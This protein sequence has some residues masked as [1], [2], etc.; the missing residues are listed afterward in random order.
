MALC[1]LALLVLGVIMVSSAGMTL[2]Q[3]QAVT[4]TSIVTSKTAM[5]MGL[6]M[7]AML[8]TALL[9]IRRL[10]PVSMR[11]DGVSDDAPAVQVADAG[12]DRRPGALSRWING[13]LRLWPL[14]LGTLGLLAVVASAYVPGIAS[15]R[16]GAH[17]WINLRL[18][19]FDSVQPSEFAKWGMVVLI[20]WFGARYARRMGSFWYGLLPGLV[21]AG[22]VSAL[23]VM[24]DLGTGALIGVSAAVMLLAAGCRWWQFALLAPIPVVGA[25]AAIIQ[26]PYRVDR[27]KAFMDP[28][29]DP[30]GIG[31]H[32]IQSMA[33]VAN[34][35]GVGRGLGNG[36]QKF[37]YL[38]EDTTDFLFAIVCEELGIAGAALVLALYVGLVWAIWVI[39]RRER[40]AVLKLIALGVMTTIGLQAVINLAV[41]TGLGPT[42]GIALPLMS[43]G[44]TGWVLIGAAL[45]LVIA[46]D[47]SQARTGGVGAARSTGGPRSAAGPI[48]DADETDAG[49]QPVVEDPV[50]DDSAVTERKTRRRKVEAAPA[51]MV[52]T[53]DN[54]AD[55]Q[56]APAP[57]PGSAL[58]A[59]P[60]RKRARDSA[61]ERDT[62][63][64]AEAATPLLFADLHE[65]APARPA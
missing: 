35:A 32:M 27:I 42:K 59:K 17:R 13:M 24:E 11:N 15:P 14:W 21:A 18:P 1:A 5:L 55:E 40:W 26:N 34:G 20:A 36:L 46:I 23:V 9:P 41:V 45:G 7:V 37:E 57:S 51:A 3:E 33:A 63:S 30:E 43:S 16:K 8:M 19:G 44:G 58:E 10:V 47:R 38:P 25:I 2:R 64:P 29:A 31:Y 4:L 56:T 48:D 62:L 61:G 53:D 39:V 52:T 12:D 6:A 65:P 50:A 22:A 28:Y 54:A 49:E 60:T